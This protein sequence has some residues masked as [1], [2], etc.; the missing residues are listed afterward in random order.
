MKFNE[1]KQFCCS[2]L[3][4]LIFCCSCT[5]EKEIVIDK[6]VYTDEINGA[7]YIEIHKD[8]TVVYSGA[9]HGRNRVYEDYKDVFSFKVSTNTFEY[10]AEEL[11]L[12]DFLSESF[13][14][15]ARSEF[16]DDFGN[17]YLRVHYNDTIKDLVIQDLSFLRIMGELRGLINYYEAE[18]V[19]E[20]LDNEFIDK[21]INWDK[22]T[23]QTRSNEEGFEKTPST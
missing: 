4:C 23:T 21:V 6:I 7:L 1:M 15:P 13:D 5:N 8:G 18:E 14:A 12:N 17:H 16:S 3:L 19:D 22:S 9:G 2:S 20:Q 10:Y 11:R